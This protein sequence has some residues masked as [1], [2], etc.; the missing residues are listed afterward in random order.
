ME[1]V[2]FQ[3][4]KEN[5][6]QV[7]IK[8][9]ELPDLKEGEIR[10]KIDRY[11]FTS[12]NVSYAVSGFSLGYWK[13]FP[14]ETPYGIIPVWGYADV[15]E[16]KH[17]GIKIGE[18]FYGYYPMST[19]CTLQ[20]IKVNPYSFTDGAPHR[21]ELAAI[22][23]NYTRVLPTSELHREELQNY[24]PIIH[25]L[26]ATSFMLYQFL[27]SQEFI[28]VEQ[29]I[30][31]SASAKTSLGLAFMLSQHKVT[32]GKKIVG[33]TS[34]GNIEFVKS[35]NYYDEVIAYDN[36]KSIT[37]DKLVVIDIRGNRNFLI[38][39]SDEFSEQIL[40][41]AR[42]GATDWTETGVH[43]DIPKAKLFFAPTPLKA[44]FKKHGPAEAIQM[45]NKASVQ[46]IQYT[47]NT[48]EVEFIS[49]TGQLTNLYLDMIKGKVNPR[50][51]YIVKHQ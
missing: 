43:S 4:G 50:K 46:F 5:I 12:N 26:F 35:T 27:K 14:S 20:P 45:I 44:F 36:Y 38:S 51:G 8:Q 41:I 7:N 29:V 33:L 9:T 47:K 40:H 18:K 6:Y 37:N 15:V 23:N 28:E 10:L 34:E 3:V 22:Y 24:A 17:E 13:F 11:A 31:T 2:I 1:N 48:I 30:I 19:Y 16:S 39:L 42:V 32:D 25:P 21:N 49:G